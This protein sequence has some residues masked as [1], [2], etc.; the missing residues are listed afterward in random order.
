MRF[1]R[2]RRRL[3]GPED[4]GQVTIFVVLAMALFLLGFVG[5]A[6]DMTNL[7]FHRQMAQ[8]AADAACQA[9]IMDVLLTAQGS[10][11]PSAGFTPGT[12][13]DCAVSPAAVPCRYATTNGYS[14]TGLVPDTPSN[15]VAVSFPG[16]VPGVNPPPASQAPVP[17][18][19]T[20]VVERVG[21]TFASMITGKRTADVHA[22]AECGLIQSKAPIPIIV[23]NPLCPHSFQMSGNPCVQII[24]GPDKSV[25]V[26]SKN[27]SAACTTNSAGC[28]IG[29]LGATCSGGGGNLAIDLSLGGPSFDGSRF[30]VWG[31]PE[32]FA[33]GFNPG[34]NGKW[35]S[36][37]FPMPDP[38]STLPP[39]APP[40]NA[41][42]PDLTPDP[43]YLA[44]IGPYTPTPSPKDP[45]AARGPHLAWGC[46]DVAGCDRY[47]PG[48]YAAAI[49][50]K[51]RTAIFD[52]GVYY[53][54]GDVSAGGGGCSTPGT[55]CN[56]KPTG[57]CHA[58]LLLEGN[59]IVR[60]STAP[61]DGSGGTT[62]YLSG[63]GGGRFGSVVVISNSG[64]RTVDPFNTAGGSPNP[65]LLSS[66]PPAVCPGTSPP[67]PGTPAELPATIPDGGV[68]GANVLLGPCSGTYADLALDEATNTTYPI[69]GV[70]FFQDRNNNDPNG[71]PAFQGTGSML[72]A[73]T[74]YFHNCPNSL[75]APCRTWPT[76]Y[77]AFLNLQGNPGSS[78]RVVGNIVTDQLTLAG[79]GQIS[80]ILDPNRVVVTIRASL[81]R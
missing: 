79:N 10:T 44:N 73:G 57:A 54:T 75:T 48:R 77:N 51:D 8:G 26:N 5:F 28:P 65:L 50:I 59:S 56:P 58:A 74:M 20:D 70:L 30:G 45:R 17:F 61:G 43:W 3:E 81:L 1:N 60:P 46:P 23:L 41:A 29:V 9:G 11:P 36:P 32:T 24:G 22:F 69:R 72:L 25:Q 38:Y 52:P 13:F 63:S 71:Q 53:I 21:L 67:T 42:A 27:E 64:A 55:G 6:V 37:G 40:A 62:F 34:A 15:Q 33:S 2:R 12:A 80:M 68:G 7:W 31:G 35:E 39:P 78:T 18:L 4:Q 49:D 47:S 19:R 66:N 16:S 76:D 14:G